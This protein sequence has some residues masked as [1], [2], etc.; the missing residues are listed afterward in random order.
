MNQLLTTPALL[1]QHMDQQQPLPT[2][3]CSHPKQ[4]KKAPGKEAS[5]SYFF[6]FSNVM[7]MYDFEIMVEIFIRNE[8]LSVRNLLNLTFHAEVIH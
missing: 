3:N 7:F 6:F 4:A 2:I 5:V 8:C 1:H